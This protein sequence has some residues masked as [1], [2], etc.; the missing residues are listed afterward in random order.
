MLLGTASKYTAMPGARA[1]YLI[2]YNEEITQK[3]ALSNGATT[4]GPNQFGQ[5]ALKHDLINSSVERREEIS[6]Y[7]KG[8]M[9]YVE[10][11]LNAISK[12]AG[13]RNIAVNQKQESGM[14]VF[15]DFSGM[16]G[17]QIPQELQEKLGKAI[18]EDDTDIAKYLI[19]ISYL[20]NGIGVAAV[21][22]S[23]FM[24]DPK[25]GFIRFV[26]NGSYNKTVEHDELL[27]KAM[28][29]V[30][31]AAMMQIPERIRNTKNENQRSL[32]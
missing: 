26:I 30:E 10:D 16:L 9:S 7:Y 3:V 13:W 21:P 6:D 11:R 8:K 25:D 17:R 32:L 23:A 31:Q 18:I 5:E 28:D 29:A 12:K 4:L 2:S 22:G 20:D 27:V 1:G 15:A 19:V 24:M 14:F